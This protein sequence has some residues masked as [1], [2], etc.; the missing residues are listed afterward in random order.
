MRL[1]RFDLNLLVVLDALLE[2]RNVTRA[3]ER[4]HI[5]QSATS[6]ALSRLRDYF[7]DSLLVQVGRRMELTPLAQSLT[8]PVR[9]ALMRARTAISI[10]PIFEPASV[11]RSFSVCVSDYLVDVLLA[12]VVRRVARAAPGIRLDLRKTPIDVLERFE[13]GTTDVLIMP[14]Q[15]ADRLQ[16]PKINIWQDEHVCMMCADAA[17]SM[18]ELT[19]DHYLDRGH[20]S[21]RL[22]DETS[23]SYEEWFLPRYG[24]QRRV[25]G[26]IDQFSA[27]PLLVMGTERIVTMHRRMAEEMAKRFPVRLF[28]APFAIEPLK[29]Y[30]VWPRYLDEDPAHRWLRDIIQSVATE[31]QGETATHAED[32]PAGS[33]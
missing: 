17:R 16:H 9:D 26:T 4:L 23:L 2:E 19:M 14:Q 7:G 28:P 15:Y 11:S 21:I 13:R 1:D 24:R 20:I 6:A 27:A 32:S 12:E 10:R 22:G 29:E 25:E 3:S 8:G 18:S 33:T 5:G 30:M 31:Y